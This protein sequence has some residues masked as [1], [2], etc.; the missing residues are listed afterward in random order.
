MKGCTLEG[1]SGRNRHLAWERVQELTA[2]EDNNESKSSRANIVLL[3]PMLVIAGVL[4]FKFNNPPVSAESPDQVHSDR[5]VSMAT[6]PESEETPEPKTDFAKRI[7]RTPQKVESEVNPAPVESREEKPFVMPEWEKIFNADGS[8]K[9][10]LN[11]SGRLVS[12]NIPD[13]IDLYDGDMTRFIRE[14]ISNGVATDMSALMGGD[15]I[16]D[17]FLY[18]GPVNAA[19]DLGNVY[20]M[21]STDHEGGPRLFTAVGRLS[22][23]ESTFIEFEFNQVPLSLGSGVPWW[24]LKGERT[25]GDL[26]VRMNFNGGSLDLVEILEWQEDAF[27]VVQSL[28]GLYFHGCNKRPAIIYCVATPRISEAPGEGFEVWDE[29]FEILDPTPPDELV[30]LAINVRELLG[31]QVDFSSTVIRT[32]QDI[33]INTFKR[34]ARDLSLAVL[35]KPE[36]LSQ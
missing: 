36:A 9:D 33:S 16:S 28:P 3:L 8:L 19:H 1:S 2:S 4:W 34:V 13:Y 12:N 23:Q 15:T 29:N 35:R 25:E 27:E 17:Q 18:N 20:F 14:I 32:P 6:Y 21:T 10:E 30:E 5:L 7:A 11:G 31:K 24:R 22:G 26:S